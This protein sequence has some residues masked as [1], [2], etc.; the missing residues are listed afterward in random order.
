MYDCLLRIPLRCHRGPQDYFLK[1]TDILIFS[2]SYWLGQ[3]YHLLPA[4]V[5]GTINQLLFQ[6]R[7][8]RATLDSSKHSI[9]YVDHSSD[10]CL[11]HVHFCP[12]LWPYS[13]PEHHVFHLHHC[14]SNHLTV[15]LALVLPSQSSV[16]YNAGRMFFLTS[17]RETNKGVLRILCHW[18]EFCE[19]KANRASETKL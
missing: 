13:S 11:K 15:L 17:S 18:G 16:F 2:T 12:S 7:I 1:C 4:L 10:I 14:D 3:L 6:A 9:Y 5:N 19:S 8:L